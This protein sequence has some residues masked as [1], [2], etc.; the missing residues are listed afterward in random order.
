MLLS[1]LY[2]GG[3]RGT[4]LVLLGAI[5]APVGLRRRVFLALWGVVPNPFTLS[6]KSLEKG[7]KKDR[8]GEPGGEY[9]NDILRFCRKWQTA[10]GL[11]LRGRIRVGALGF[12]TLCVHVCEY[13]K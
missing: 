8:I 2:F 1:F 12:D 5:L 10:F 3:L 6:R 13:E 4:S 9:F 11:R 7:T